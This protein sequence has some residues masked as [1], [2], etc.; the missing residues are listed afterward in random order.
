M[1]WSVPAL[2][3]GAVLVAAPSGVPNFDAGP[4]C[5]AGADSGIDIQPNVDGCLASER[6]ARDRLVKQWQEFSSRDKSQCVALTSLGGPPS[7]IEVLTC[8]EMER[9]ARAMRLK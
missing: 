4:G 5:R 1:L 8:L 2:A 9:D 7:Y 6:Q 3:V